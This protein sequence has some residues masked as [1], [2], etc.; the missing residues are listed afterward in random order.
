MSNFG[1]SYSCYTEKRAVEYSIEVLRQVYPEC[2]VYLVSDGGGNYTFLEEKFDNL[3]VSHEEDMRG[4][5]QRKTPEQNTSNMQDKLYATAMSWIERNKAAVDFCNKPYMLMM[6]PD[7]LVRG[8]FSIPQ[9]AK[10]IA[11]EIINFAKRPD[12]EAGWVEVLKKIPGSVP[13]PGWSW[14]FI[15][16]SKAFNEVYKFVKNNDELF[17]EFVLADWEFGSAGDVTL[18]VLF[19]A[20]G[21]PITVFHEATDCARNGSWRNSHHAILHA[22]REQYPKNEY[23][24]RHAG[25]Q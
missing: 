24:G 21:Y 19:A 8:K 22:Y 4:W 5:C 23:D 7:V 2:P 3:K 9:D 17:R 10:L 13:C 12:N 1:V 20:C 11:P 25:E 15:Y 14:P 18:P 6:E 16:E